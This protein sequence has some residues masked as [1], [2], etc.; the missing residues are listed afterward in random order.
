LLRGVQVLVLLCVVAWAQTPTILPSATIRNSLP[1]QAVRAPGQQAVAA[2]PAPA[3][4]EG[5][6]ARR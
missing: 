6:A 3:S 5:G 1:A 4:A 2:H